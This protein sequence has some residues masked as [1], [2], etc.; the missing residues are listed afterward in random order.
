[1][2]AEND[3]IRAM[4]K[5][6]GLKDMAVSF[7]DRHPKQI[8]AALIGAG[9]ATGLQL[10]ANHSTEDKPSFE[11]RSARA[12]LRG[13]EESMAKAKLEGREPSFTEDM[14]HAVSKSLSHVADV[15]A[16]HPVRSALTIAAPGGALSGL[17][18]LRA[19]SS[20]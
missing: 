12:A 2:S 13:S 9:V 11:Q 10:A 14:G 1:M 20:T 5:K 19:L 15:S 16:R 6:A 8:A 7:I 3:F 17:A 4:T 18:I